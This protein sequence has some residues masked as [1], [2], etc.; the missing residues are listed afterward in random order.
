MVE[1]NKVL[2]RRILNDF[3]TVFEFELPEILG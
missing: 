1:D 2:F 3:V